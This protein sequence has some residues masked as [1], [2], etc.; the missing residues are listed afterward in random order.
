ML[1]PLQKLKI[2]N[3]LSFAN[4]L[5]R[6]MCQTSNVIPTG[7]M[8]SFSCPFTTVL[9]TV[10]KCFHFVINQN[11]LQDNTISQN[12][13]AELTAVLCVDPRPSAE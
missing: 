3:L 8:S 10:L 4:T 2:R 1:R 7:E 12:Q 13:K 6:N 9:G 5:R 11:V